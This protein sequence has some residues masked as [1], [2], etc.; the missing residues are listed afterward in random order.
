MNKANLKSVLTVVRDMIRRN[1]ERGMKLAQSA[2]EQSRAARVLASKAQTTAEAAQTTSNQA[3]TTSNQAQTTAN[4]ARTTA[5]QAQ[6]TANQAQTTA[7]QAQTTAEA[8]QTTASKCVQYEPQTLTDA[9]KTRARL[10]IGATNNYNDLKNRPCYFEATLVCT[11]T[12]DTAAGEFYYGNYDTSKTTP[13]IESGTQYFVNDKTALFSATEVTIKLTNSQVVSVYCIGNLQLLNQIGIDNLQSIFGLYSAVSTIVSPKLLPDNGLNFCVGRFTNNSSMT[14]Y[15]TISKTS[16]QYSV[17]KVTDLKTLDE[18]MIPDSIARVAD[19]TQTVQKI[20]SLDETNKVS[21]RSLDS[22][23]YV[24]YGYFVPYE[25]TTS[26]MTFS[27]NVLVN[28]VKDS[29][30]SHAQIF[31]PYN[32]CVQYLK[33]T[34]TTYDRKNIYLNNLVSSGD[35]VIISSST[36]GSTKKFKI[37]VD[38]TGAISATEVTA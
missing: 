1:A 35:D 29:A 30:E 37:A 38:D 22:G 18:A 36:E 21:I 3:Q 20:E 9:Q 31:Y 12:A 8:A 2:M 32:N 7:N 23:S 24:L 10:N 16:D 15:G 13:T 27:D 25:G 4:Q 14:H 26:T 6:T 33:I 5:N 17:Y 11:D 19:L 34:D 28:V